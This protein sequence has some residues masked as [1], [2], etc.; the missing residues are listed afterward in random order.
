VLSEPTGYKILGNEHMAFSPVIRRSRL[1]VV[2]RWIARA[3]RTVSEDIP[4]PPDEVRAFYIDLTNIA[5]VH[6][7][8]VS[9]QTLDRTQTADGYVQT[10]RVGDRIPF[11][12]LRLRTNYLARLYVP[13]AGEVLAEARQFPRV[14]LRSTVSFEPT[15]GFTRVV[16]RIRIEAPLPLAAVTTRKAVQ[17]HTEMLAGI[18][19]RFEGV[20]R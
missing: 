15:A 13:V 2:N 11:G 7:L 10:Y 12:P 14:H 3:E 4:G 8:V 17:A 6:P 9:V 5:L 19:R 20:R 1:T 16:E 18:R